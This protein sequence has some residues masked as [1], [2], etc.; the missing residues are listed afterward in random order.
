M[1]ILD[2][3]F[4]HVAYSSLMASV[5]VL[6][7]LSIK[8]IFYQRIGA[9]LHHVM[10]ILVLL[11]LLM[12]VAI[13][14]PF[15]IF[16]F[17]PGQAQIPINLINGNTILNMLPYTHDSLALGQ[18]S[19]NN[20]KANE[21]QVDGSPP[22]QDLR[23]Q[24]NNNSTDKTEQNPYQFIL[25]LLSRLWLIGVLCLFLFSNIIRIRFMRRIKVFKKL[26]DPHIELLVEKCSKKLKIKKSIPVYIAPYFKSPCITGT[27]NPSIYLPV[28][29]YN[30]VNHGQLQHIFLHELA[31]YKRKDLLYSFFAKLAVGIHWFN[32]LIWL[33]VKQ[34]RLDREIA[35][36]AYVMETLGEN[37]TRP[38]GLTLINLSKI[39]SNRHRQLRLESFFGTNNQL[40]RRI[41]MISRFKKGSYRLSAVAVL[42]LML[43]GAATLTN[44]ISATNEPKLINEFNE[45]IAEKLVVIDP[46]HG[47]VDMGAIYP[48]IETDSKVAQ[49]IAQVKEKDLNLAISLMLYDMLKKSGIR[50]EMTRHEDITLELI[51]RVELANSLNASLFVSIHNNASNKSSDNGTMTYFNP[52]NN[53][54]TNGITGEKAAQIVHEQMVKDLGTTDG[55]VKKISI[56]VLNDTKMPAVVAN[57]A[58]IT[59]DSD[60]QNL[61]SETFQIKTAQAL[62]DG[63]IKVL[64]EMVSAEVS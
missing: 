31:H 54:A 51:D 60:R 47:G 9:K 16:N 55:G 40:E 10:W 44:A 28:G 24:I 36:D 11:R 35:C 22:A 42:C 43:I 52:L 8:K 30:K 34:M 49:E 12:P 19:L 13:E 17:F 4:L 63:I 14:S 1:D 41:S 64:N 33:A 57:P 62:H 5:L 39:F 58:Y 7:L 25:K 6:L 53:S 56:I 32:P 2:I 48:F 15:S 46:G 3:V 45:R 29:I 23:P 50:V 59:N 18:L 27:I 20:K 37:E 61:M 21:H 38:Y 26:D